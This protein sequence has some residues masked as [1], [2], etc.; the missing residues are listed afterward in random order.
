MKQVTLNISTLLI[1]ML[2]L[3]HG[4]SFGQ[5]ATSNYVVKSTGAGTTCSQI[6]DNGTNTGIGT[7]SLLSFYLTNSGSPDI[8]P[9]LTLQSPGGNASLLIRGGSSGSTG[10]W[11]DMGFALQNSNNSRYLAHLFR[12]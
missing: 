11:P 6:Y 7:T 2:L 9:R 1:V 10:Y 3:G 5:C 8:T 12:V 4:K